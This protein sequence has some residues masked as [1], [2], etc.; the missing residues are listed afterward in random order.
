MLSKWSVE[1]NKE[2]PFLVDHCI[3]IIKSFGT[4]GLELTMTKLNKK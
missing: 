3:E 1:E 2:L 4:Q